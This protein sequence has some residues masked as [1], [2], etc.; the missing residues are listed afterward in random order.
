MPIAT[1]SIA[2]DARLPVTLLSGFLGAGK[3]T[4]LEH[5]LKSKD[6]GLKCA[7]E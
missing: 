2:T 4:L 5:I 6:H 1:S 3:T 7:G